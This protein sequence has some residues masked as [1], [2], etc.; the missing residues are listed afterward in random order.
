MKKNLPIILG[1]IVSLF[2]SC[3]NKKTDLKLTQDFTDSSARIQFK[4]PE[5]WSFDSS[6]AKFKEDI[7]NEKDLFQENITIG[8]EII[9]AGFP[10]SQYAQGFCTR[11]KLLDSNYKQLTQEDKKLNNLNAKKIVF[12][13][14][15]GDNNYKSA[16][17]ITIKDSFAYFLQCNAVDTSF[18]THENTFDQI[19]NTLKPF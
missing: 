1:C 19:I 17:Y 16:L 14:K 11:Y 15:Y 5:N 2:F 10:L 13:T 12:T 6:M 7:Y 18:V 8:A 4:Y 9:P 3:Q